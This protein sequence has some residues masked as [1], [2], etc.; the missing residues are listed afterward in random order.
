MKS[1]VIL[2][3]N[4]FTVGIIFQKN[5]MQMIGVEIFFKA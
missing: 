4:K 1:L 3:K 5:P 2:F